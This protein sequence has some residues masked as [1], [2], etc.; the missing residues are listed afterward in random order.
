L[1]K[2]R[3]MRS[4][5]LPPPF[6]P[7]PPLPNLWASHAIWGLKAVYAPPRPYPA[8]HLWPRHAICDLKVFNKFFFD[9]IFFPY[10]TP[11]ST[12]RHVVYMYMY[13]FKLDSTKT[14]RLT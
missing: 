4:P 14:Q 8:P 7:P 5:P 9:D 3:H 13:I 6:P 12:Q 10:C 2:P 11:S 1:T